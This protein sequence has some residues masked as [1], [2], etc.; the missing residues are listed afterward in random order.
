MLWG[1]DPEIDHHSK[2]WF[3]STMKHPE[4]GFFATTSIA[5]QAHVLQKVWSW[6]PAQPRKRNLAV[7]ASVMEGN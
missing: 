2:G 1:H 6:N 7:L 3:H 4:H 5:V